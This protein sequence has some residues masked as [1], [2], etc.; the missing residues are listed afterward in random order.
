MCVCELIICMTIT[1]GIVSNI[2]NKLPQLKHLNSH[3]RTN[4][5]REFRHRWRYSS[6]N[7]HNISCFEVF[8]HKCDGFDN[9]VDHVDI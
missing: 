6:F 8:L 3:F 7:Q 2:Y 9:K 1:D 5:D 4:D